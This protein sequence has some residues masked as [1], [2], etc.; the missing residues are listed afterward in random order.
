MGKLLVA[1]VLGAVAVPVAWI[2]AAFMG[3]LPVEATADPPPWEAKLAH[4]ALEASLEGRASRIESA[5]PSSDAALLAGMKLYVNNC[6][7]CHG[8]PGAPSDWGTKAFY[9]RVPQFAE[10]PSNL[11]PAEMFIV[12]R[13]GVRYSGMGAWDDLMPDEDIWRVVAFLSSLR[14]LPPDVEALWTAKARG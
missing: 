3:W 5:M 13:H 7:G 4:R 9:P 2:I 8:R 11:E 1:F 14:K 12:V 10:R 6:S